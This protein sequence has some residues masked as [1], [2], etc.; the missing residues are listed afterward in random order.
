MYVD[1]VVVQS[2]NCAQLFT[3]QWTAAREASLSFTISQRLL[4]LMSSESVMPSSHLILCRPLLLLP[5][6]FPSQPRIFLILGYRISDAISPSI[7]FRIDWFDPLA[8]PGTLK[9]LLQHH[10]LK[11]SILWCSAFFMVQLS[12]QY[13]STGKPI[14]LTI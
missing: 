14:A 7:F 9:S 2:P 12:Y 1:D 4:E 5:P 13:L 11:A 8:V 3:T 10:N 6:I